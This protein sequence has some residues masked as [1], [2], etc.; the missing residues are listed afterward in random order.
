MYDKIHHKLKKNKIKKNKIKNKI[1]GNTKKKKEKK[2][3]C[4]SVFMAAL[5]TKA[6]IGSNIN[7]HLQMNG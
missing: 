6:R 7:L 2:D 3:I 1:K 4:T 5:F